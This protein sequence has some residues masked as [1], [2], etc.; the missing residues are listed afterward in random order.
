MLI[1]NA[2][3]PVKQSVHNTMLSQTNLSIY[4]LKNMQHLLSHLCINFSLGCEVILGLKINFT[5]R[6]IT[7]NCGSQEDT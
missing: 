4:W 3:H 5:L 7:D 1:V 6:K 2:A